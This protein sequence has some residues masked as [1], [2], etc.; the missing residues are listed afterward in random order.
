MEI[1]TSV[2]SYLP[3]I[4]I[5]GGSIILIGWIGFNI[6]VR[7]KRRIMADYDR[8]VREEYTARGKPTPVLILR[9]QNG[10]IN[11]YNNLC[12]RWPGRM[13]CYRPQPL[14]ESMIV[15]T[16]DHNNLKQRTT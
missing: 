4:G 14:K 16:G 3:A 1:W 7:R 9:I 2:S 6:A 13:L 5:A 15:K 12:A 8:F 11:E 10:Y